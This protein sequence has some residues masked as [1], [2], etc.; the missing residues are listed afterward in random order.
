MHNCD[1]QYVLI[2]FSAVQICELSYIQTR[3]KEHKDKVRLT[4]EDIRK[5][6]TL[7]AE[8]RMG[9]EDGG[10][11]RHT[12]ELQSGVY[13]TNAEIVARERGF[14]KNKQKSAKELSHYDKDIAECSFDHVETWEPILNSFF[15]REKECRRR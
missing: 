8:K 13:W 9:K 5:G 1:D 7:S 11:V 10:L 4:N 2:S 6:N 3:K 15:D 12:I 14:I